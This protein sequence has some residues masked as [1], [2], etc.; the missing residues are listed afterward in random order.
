MLYHG[1]V[2]NAY[3]DLGLAMPPA[4]KYSHGNKAITS[5]GNPRNGPMVMLS[6]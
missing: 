6:V 2:A 1:E 3:L 4:Y 5:L